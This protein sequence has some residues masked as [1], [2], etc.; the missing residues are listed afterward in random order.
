MKLLPFERRYQLESTPCDSCGGTGLFPQPA[1][2]TDPVCWNCR[3]L[4]RRVTRDGRELFYEVAELLGVPV[5]ERESRIPPKHFD[6]IFAK[7]VVAGMKVGNAHPD[8][9]R[10]PCVVHMV[11]HVGLSIALQFE[12]GTQERVSPHDTFKRELTEKELRC[13]DALMTGYVGK[14]AVDAS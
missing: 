7:N 3:G 11:T 2:N 13:V 10:A 4:G 9:K 12:D 6:L 5:L 14:G 8:R 1:P